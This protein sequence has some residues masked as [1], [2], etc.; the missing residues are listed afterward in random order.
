LILKVDIMEI[1]YKRNI[2][3][4]LRNYD[5]YTLLFYYVVQ[6]FRKVKVKIKIF[7]LNIMKCLS[8]NIILNIFSIPLHAYFYLSIK[9]FYIKASYVNI[10]N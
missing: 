10:N 2:N 6:S 4:Y 8:K 3:Y 7:I 1:N 5:K 9:I